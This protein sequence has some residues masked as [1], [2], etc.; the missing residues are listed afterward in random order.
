M[1]D[2]GITKNVPF[3]YN[4]NDNE[5]ILKVSSQNCECYANMPLHVGC[6]KDVEYNIDVELKR[7]TTKDTGDTCILQNIF[8]T[9][10]NNK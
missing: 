7:C 1:N 6:K 10:N 8:N 2:K 4:V 3:W 5:F 9:S